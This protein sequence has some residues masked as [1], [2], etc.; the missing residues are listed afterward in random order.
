MDVIQVM[1]YNNLGVK[2][3]FVPLMKAG[4]MPSRTDVRFT[5]QPTGS[6]SDARVVSPSNLAS[7]EFGVCMSG[8]IKQVS[9]PP[10]SG[11]PQSVTFPFVM[12]G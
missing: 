1:L 12:G 4:T 2:K 3:C 7:G 5:I 9:F 11:G 8:A 6:V 10:F